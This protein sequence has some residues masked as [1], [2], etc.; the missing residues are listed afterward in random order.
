M[1]SRP[2]KLQRQHGYTLVELVM[3]ITIL[4]VV[5]SMMAIFMRGPID[6]YF[7]V[8][9]RAALSDLSDTVFRRIERDVRKA[10]PNSLRTPSTAGANQCLEFIPT[11]IGGRYRSDDT[12]AGLSFDA[13]DTSFNMLWRNSSL[14]ADQQIVINDFIAVYNLG[15]NVPTNDAYNQNSPR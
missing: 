1:T 5:S 4:G 12:A 10:L 15:P 8:A 9:R 11:K 6:A 14:P 7:A 13:A 2:T 3:V